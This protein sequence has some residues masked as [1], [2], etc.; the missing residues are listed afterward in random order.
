MVSYMSRNLDVRFGMVSSIVMIL[1]EALTHFKLCKLV[2][3]RYNI[4]DPPK[5]TVELSDFQPE[6]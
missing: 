4:F 1:Y 2:I 5:W 3:C 6:L